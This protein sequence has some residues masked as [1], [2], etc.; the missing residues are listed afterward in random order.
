MMPVPQTG[1]PVPQA[2]AAGT[3]LRATLR[4]L[5]L[6]RPTLQEFASSQ[7]KTIVGAM[8]LL[9]F[10]F[11][12]FVIPSESM[13]RTLLVGD[14][15]L[16]NKQ[17]FAPAGKLGR[18]LM[19]YRGVQRGDIVI[20]R[21]PKPGL[22]VKRVIGLPGDELRIAQ[23][24]VYINGSRLDEPYAV[25]EPT[26]GRPLGDD[27]PALNSI[28]PRIDPSWWRQLQSLTVNGALRIPAGC[29]FVLGDNRNHSADSREWG[30]VERDKIVAR[31][32]VIYFSLRRPSA[33]DPLQ[34]E[35]DRLGFGGE[36]SGWKRFAR[37][38]RIFTVVR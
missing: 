25:F 10:I 14:F 20:F 1:E 35:D 15:L 21:H 23:G 12:P 4:H 33:T 13:E 29:Y 26:L 28:D 18:W 8:F 32:L 27:F 24:Q 38:N 19:P 17:I 11:Q 3:G 34:A 37:W 16:M 36:H 6:H 9:T 22:L 5:H 31:P 2:A 7:M 30:L